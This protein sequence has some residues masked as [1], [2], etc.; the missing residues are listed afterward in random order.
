MA[1]SEASADSDLVLSYTV[2]HG[3][4]GKE[5]A[6]LQQALSQGYRVVDVLQSDA[7]VGG[8]GTS[9]GHTCVT[10]VLT[11]DANRMPYIVTHKGH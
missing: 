3:G 2:H 11:K 8:G 1:E 10:V 6:A 7:D 4:I 5:Y 9:I